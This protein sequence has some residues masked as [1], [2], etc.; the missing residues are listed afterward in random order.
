MI[1]GIVFQ[2]LLGTLEFTC[3][4]YFIKDEADFWRVDYCVAPERYYEVYSLIENSIKTFY[5]VK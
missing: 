2:T 4:D 1:K 5:L 3:V